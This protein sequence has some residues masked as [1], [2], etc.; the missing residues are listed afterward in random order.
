MKKILILLFIIMGI[1]VYGAK[2]EITVNF[3]YEPY[4]ANLDP[5]LSESITAANIIP[6][7]FEGLIK[8][9]ENGEP[10]PGIAEKWER[11]AEGLVWTFYLR[12]AEWEN[13]DP[14]TANDFKFAWIRALDSKNAAEYA[15][16]LF[17]IKGAYE[18]N[19]GM[20]NIE[21]LGIKVI[22]EKTLEVTL[23]SPTRYLDSLLT[24]PVY[25]PINEKY[26]N[27][28]KDEYGKDAG[29][30]MSNGAYKL[31]KWEHYDE[32]VLEKN[33]NYWNEKEVKTEKIRI[34][35]INDISKSL[36]A[37]ENNEIAFTVITPELYT[38][39]RKD[40]RLISYDDGSAWYLEYNLEND[41]LANKKIR[42]ALTIAIDKEELGSIL[43]A[44]GKPAYGYVPGF[45]Q[46]VDKSF[47]KEAGNT[48]PHYNSKKAK[49]LFEEGLK[50]L[51]FN[52]APEITLIFNDQGNN[53]KI[54]EY[55]QG[56]IKKEL[57][58][59][60]K[61]KSL[62]FK[63]RLERMTQKTFEIVLAGWSGDFND[64]LSYMDIWTTGGG[65]NHASY[66]NPKYDE[67]I[68]I[69]QTSSDQKARIKAMI[70]AEK[71]LG[72]DMPIGMLYFRQKVFLVNPE[73]KNM[74]FKPVGSEYYLIDAYIE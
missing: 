61:I 66:S 68:Q 57:G 6:L 47:R 71:I 36:E 17:P 52:E 26:F 20:G 23:N 1:I 53:K 37:F 3:E 73:L 32:L 69:A 4:E 38:E 5:Q 39:Y 45:V 15:Y 29:K 2:N 19:V 43:Q 56:K 31:V 27:L 28:Y 63:E 60:L 9:N 70:E 55:I 25:S 42:Q 11:N 8:Q 30:I 67:L 33:K 41:F 34:K 7:L 12:E 16:M 10:V 72:D 59:N 74:K 54:A 24:F 51:N 48:Y 18:F 40:K 50:E 46:G 49:K 44:M 65:N 22:D 58:Y 35:L 13:G 64:A 14:V 62:P 21:E